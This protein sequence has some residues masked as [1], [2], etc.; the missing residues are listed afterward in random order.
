MALLELEWNEWIVKR[1][2][3]TLDIPRSK[4]NH[5]RNDEGRL[6]VVPAEAPIGKHAGRLGQS[7]QYGRMNEPRSNCSERSDLH[8]GWLQWTDPRTRAHHFGSKFFLPERTGTEKEPTR[9]DP[10]P[11]RTDPNRPDPIRTDLYPT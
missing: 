7:D 3:M 8:A 4:A 10:D 9:I 1:C 2:G 6:D 11:K 5:L